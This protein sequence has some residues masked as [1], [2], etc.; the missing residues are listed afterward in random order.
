MEPEVNQRYLWVQWIIVITF[1][2]FV[3]ALETPSVFAEDSSIPGAIV[4]SAE[5]PVPTV[6]A[7]PPESPPVQVSP[8][9]SET[10]SVSDFQA[11][12]KPLSVP[13]TP[14]GVSPTPPSNRT[15]V[16][17]SAAASVS[18]ASAAA[19]PIVNDLFTAL[20]MAAPEADTPSDIEVEDPEENVKES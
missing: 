13:T 16:V 11:N 3:F 15:F 6:P 17:I 10:A 5:N 12:S 7:N 1:F 2:I 14:S 8:P 4:P 9:Q 20:S 19:I 18:S